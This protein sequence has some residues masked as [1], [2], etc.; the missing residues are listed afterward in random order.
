MKATTFHGLWLQAFEITMRHITSSVICRAACHL[1]STLLTAGMVEYS[2][3]NHLIGSMISSFD[4]NGPTVC[5]D[6]SN[7]FLSVIAPLRCTFNLGSMTETLERTL[8]WLFTRWSPSRSRYTLLEI[9][10]LISK[11]GMLHDRAHTGRI[12]QL[13]PTPSVVQLLSICLGLPLPK[14][15]PGATQHLGRVSQA[16]LI[17]IRKRKLM[18]YLLLDTDDQP[19]PDLVEI[20]T[21]AT[22]QVNSSNLQQKRLYDLI[23]EYLTTETSAIFNEVFQPGASKGALTITADMVQ[24]AISLAVVDQAMLGHSYGGETRRKD[25]L[26]SSADALMKKLIARV[27]DSDAPGDLEGGLY[28]FMLDFS[29]VGIVQC[30]GQD[31]LSSGVAAV[32]QFFDNDLWRTRSSATE[33]SANSQNAMDLDDDLEPPRSHGQAKEETS[34][35]DISHEEISAAT[36]YMAFRACQ[37]AKMCFISRP[38]LESDDET[39]AESAMTFKEAI[40]APTFI[41]YLTHLQPQEFLSCRQVLQEIFKSGYRV[42][43]KEASTLLVYIAQELLEPYEFERCEVALG[44]CLDVLTGLAELWTTADLGEVTDIGAEMYTW[45]IRKALE[46]G[47]ASPHVQIGIST[48]LQR[49][50]RVDPEYAKSLSLESARTSL[51]RV[52]QEGSLVVKYHVGNSI[53]EI[54]GLFI[55]KEHENILQDIVT[56]LPDTADHVEGI[57]LRLYVFS[58]LGAAWSTLLRRCVYHILETPGPIPD[59]RGYA[60]NCISYLTVSLGLEDSRELFRLFASQIIYT[61]LETQPLRS[62]P[63]DIFDYADIDELL[64]DVQSDVVGQMIMRGRDDEA[65]QLASDLQRSYAQLLEDSFSKVAAYSIA[66]DLSISSSQSAQMPGAEARVR[67]VLGKEK[68]SSLVTAHFPYILA[69][70]YR[71]LDEEEHI[72][73]GFSKHAAFGNALVAYQEMLATSSSAGVLPVNQQPSFKSRLLIAEMDHLCRRSIFELDSMW[74]PVLYVYV[75]RELLSGVHPALGSSH[76]CAIIRRIRILICM[77]DSTALMGYPLEMALHSLRP[78]LTDTQCSEDSIGI[79]QYLLSH[80]ESYL[81]AVPSFLVGIAVSTLT[82]TKAFLSSTQESTTQESQYKATMTKANAFHVWFS[83]YLGRYTSA[84]L[85]GATEISFKAIIKAAKNVRDKGNAKKGS[86]ES[87]LLLE[88]LEDQRSERNL[89]DQTSRKL[90]LNLLCSAF[91]SPPTFREDILGDDQLAARY[92]GVIWKTCQRA[93]CGQDF[94][95]WAGRVLGRAFAGKGSARMHVDHDPSQGIASASEP[96]S[97]SRT[98]VLKSLCSILLVEDRTEVGAVEKTLRMIM[99]KAHG[100]EYFSDCEQALPETLMTSMLWD[101]HHPVLE[102]SKSSPCKSLSEC[103]NCDEGLSVSIWIQQL[104]IA[105]AMT[106]DEDPILSEL[107]R[108][109][110]VVE[111]LAKQIFPFVLHLVLLNEVGGHE[112]TKRIISEAIHEWF[113]NDKTAL[114]PHVTILLRAIL[115]LRKQPLPNE[116]AKADRSRW[117]EIDY[118]NAASAAVRCSMF[119]T[120]LMFLEMSHSEAAKAS[121][122]SS[123]IK[124]EELTKMLL[125]IYQ[126]INEQDSFY[127]V[128]Q[129]SSLASLTSRLEYEQAGSKSLSFRGAHFDSQIRHAKEASYEDYE[130]MITVLNTL[131]LHGLSQSL[132]SKMTESGHAAVESMLNTARKLE[133]WDISVPASHSGDS[134]TIFRALQGINNAVDLDT[135]FSAI[136]LGV[137]DAMKML[138]TSNDATSAAPKTLAVLASL[139][140]ADEVFSSRSSAELYEV[141][142]KCEARAEW[143]RIEG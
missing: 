5:V 55:L 124:F 83:D 136:N 27:V 84:Q 36:G 73:K 62:L 20:P 80:G 31:L 11:P 105:L 8:G 21:K 13:C 121:R 25:N 133:Q 96:S 119:K 137:S 71:T 69:T 102:P 139:T 63:Y 51:F 87:E 32:T 106:G 135:A 74:S 42:G 140:E 28:E 76:A 118:N 115:Y 95:L 113:K 116:L 70:F 81:K 117:L 94:L 108:I 104:C 7:I 103:A 130:S 72:Q 29:A 4:L 19:D 111:G 86:Y 82:A 68:Y 15:K 128:Q 47:I 129:P 79:F 107:P 75:F 46:R 3:V 90:I 43:E 22:P 33:K 1:L 30:S 2:D 142:S 78:F 41:E 61:W 101:Q 10:D 44:M 67:K 123:G 100:T 6:S 60:Q 89:L 23:L 40:I 39:V 52:L 64:K 99:N 127:G 49:V 65:T 38:F 91:E 97:A 93:D 16:H 14:S 45:L 53:S 109:L 58:R 54:F 66:R 110:R 56:R 131:D 112:K 92:A 114:I 138:I 143:M 26:Q 134:S 141:W 37:A 120:A 35:V 34:S 85:T 48:M 50:I 132:L 125:Q 88:L 126:N 24:V 57:A 122:R 9:I 77:A 17:S 98:S 18:R 59:S 12:A